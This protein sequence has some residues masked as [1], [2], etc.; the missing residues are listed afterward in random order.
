MR[1]Q[2][3]HVQEEL[4]VIHLLAQ[5]LQVVS[6]RFVVGASKID[7]QIDQSS[8]LGDSSVACDIVLVQLKLVNH[9]IF[10]TFTPSLPL[11]ADFR[12]AC[13][14]LKEHFLSKSLC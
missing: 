1:L 10:A 5:L 14:V 6:K 12:E 4:L 2:I 8:S 7:L 11:V 3:V 9:H 13:F